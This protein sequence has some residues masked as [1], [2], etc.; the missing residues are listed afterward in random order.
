MEAEPA[1]N[2]PEH[3]DVGNQAISITNS[4]NHRRQAGVLTPENT[5]HRST[6]TSQTQQEV[7]ED[8]EDDLR[9]Q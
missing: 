4:H 7:E 5:N 2:S 6:I 3:I 9:L 1:N 8:D